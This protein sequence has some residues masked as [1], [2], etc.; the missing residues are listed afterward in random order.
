LQ[1]EIRRYGEEHWG[2]ETQ[3]KSRKALGMSFSLIQKDE[4]PILLNT[5]RKI[6]HLKS[7]KSM[8][9]SSP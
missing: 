7:L 5:K 4:P 8:S 3:N 2:P 6:F 9:V 1:K